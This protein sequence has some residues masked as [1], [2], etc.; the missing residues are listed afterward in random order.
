MGQGDDPRR[1]QFVAI[2]VQSG[3]PRELR[4]LLVGDRCPD[5]LAVSFPP[6]PEEFVPKGSFFVAPIPDVRWMIEP[7]SYQCLSFGSCS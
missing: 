6:L 5:K 7:K 3:R 2:H 4:S 1:T